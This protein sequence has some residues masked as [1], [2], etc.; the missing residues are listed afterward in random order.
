MSIF[1]YN[2]KHKIITGIIVI[3]WAVY[4][5]SGGR[6]TNIYGNKGELLQ[7]GNIKDGKNHG[8][9][10]WYYENGNK[11]MEGVFNMGMREGEWLTYNQKGKIVSKSHYENDKLNGVSLTM[12]HDGNVIEKK[13][14]E[15][16]EV[17]TL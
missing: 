17:V 8:K 9:W 1:K 16:D 10:I 13:V 14:Y 6:E 12:D 2:S 3:L 4:S 15:N 7:V 5:F 11:K